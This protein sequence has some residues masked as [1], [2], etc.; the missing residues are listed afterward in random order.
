MNLEDILAE[1][2]FD[3]ENHRQAYLGPRVLSPDHQTLPYK[4]SLVSDISAH[5]FHSD[6][7]NNSY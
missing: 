5:R 3:Q 1:E 7:P 6:L 4:Q 2:A